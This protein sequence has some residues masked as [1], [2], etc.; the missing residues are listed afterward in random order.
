MATTMAVVL[1]IV[2]TIAGTD[3]MTTG[4]D[5]QDMIEI[6]ER[7]IGREIGKVEIMGVMERDA[8]GILGMIG[9]TGMMEKDAVEIMGVKITKLH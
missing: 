3:I 4:S 9:I 1:G 2:G 5:K 8:V 6:V 7:D